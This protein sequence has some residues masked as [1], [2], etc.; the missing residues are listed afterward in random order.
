VTLIRAQPGA[1]V[2]LRDY[3]VQTAK[4]SK[5]YDYVPAEDGLIHPRD[6]ADGRFMGPNGMSLRPPG[7]MI[8]GYIATIPKIRVLEIPAGTPIPPTLVL[9]HEHSDHYSV[10][11]TEVVTPDVFNARL[12]EWLNKYAEK[13]DRDAFQTRYPHLDSESIGM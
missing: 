4:A 12:T 2:K 7:I 10:Q 3:F 1:S 11:T 6:P 5:S 8:S 9:L 13:Y